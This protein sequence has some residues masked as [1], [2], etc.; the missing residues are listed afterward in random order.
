MWPAVSWAIKLMTPAQGW[1]DLIQ[2]CNG[3][4][5]DNWLG[6]PNAC[7]LINVSQRRSIVVVEMCAGCAVQLP[8]YNTRGRGL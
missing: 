6:L 4:W 1:N 7:G 3:V 8:L 5:L 2:V